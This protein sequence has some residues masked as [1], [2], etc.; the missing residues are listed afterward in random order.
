MFLQCKRMYPRF[1]EVCRN[2]TVFRAKFQPTVT[3]THGQVTELMNFHPK[4]LNF[5]TLMSK[6]LEKRFKVFVKPRSLHYVGGFANEKNSYYRRRL[7]TDSVVVQIKI[8]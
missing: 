1:Y 2:L 3:F 7:R 6:I 5:H 8:I 4:S